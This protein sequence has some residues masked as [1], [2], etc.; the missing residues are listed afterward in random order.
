MLSFT[1][2]EEQQMLVNT[3][4]KFAETEMRA[5]AHE[6]DESGEVPSSL[7]N[8]GWEMGL[9]PAGIPEEYGGFGE[10]YSILT[11]VL[12][13]EELAWGDLSIALHIL[14]PALFATPV[15][16]QGTEEQKQ[17][18]LPRFCE[19]SFYPA[20]AAFVEPLFQFDPYAMQTTATREGDAYI[21][22]GTKAYVPLADQADVM[23]VYANE[24]GVTQAFIVPKDTPGLTV[25]QREKLMGLR[26]LPTYRVTLDG[27][28]IP[29]A[30]KL[31]GEKGVDFE[32]L[33]AYMRVATAAAAVGVARASFEYA[34]DYAKQRVQFGEPIAHRQ[35]IAFMLA[36]M[37]IDIDGL[38]LMTWEAAWK[39]DRGEDATR[40]AYLA[41]LTADDVAVEVTDRGVQIL[42]GYGYIR[43]Y[44]VERWLR[45]G[46][47]IATFEGLI[48]I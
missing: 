15:L 21:L 33:L 8:T 12:A 5:H 6:S 38:R 10:D 27:V 9:I 28:K 23:L 22:T 35:S 19:E 32:R 3:L 45:N 25:E 1:P 39:L 37:A 34:R 16:L 24:G 17:E 42:G 48:L 13:L 20:T 2:S 40:E 30:N 46:R 7:V 4:H 18:Y 29:A 26:A 31:G 14:T 43:E 44:P 47:G 11:G 36:E 41:K